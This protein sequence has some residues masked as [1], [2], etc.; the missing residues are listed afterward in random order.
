MWREWKKHN[1]VILRKKSQIITNLMRSH[2]IVGKKWASRWKHK[3]IDQLFLFGGVLILYFVTILTFD[4]LVGGIFLLH[5]IKATADS[6]HPGVVLIYLFQLRKGVCCN[7]CF[8]IIAMQLPD[9]W[10]LQV[11]HQW[12]DNQLIMC[13]WRGC[14]EALCVL[15][16]MSFTPLWR[17][18]VGIQETWLMVPEVLELLFPWEHRG[19]FHLKAKSSVSNAW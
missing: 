6:T 7:Y 13:S 5:Q 3:S 12:Q 17:D 8:S 10:Y 14:C 15:V 1:L 9:P 18:V 2:H 4:Y 11:V 19:P 16:L